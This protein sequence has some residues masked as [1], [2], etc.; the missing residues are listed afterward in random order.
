MTAVLN[1]NEQATI[2]VIEPP[3]PVAVEPRVEALQPLRA[4]KCGICT[5]TDGCTNCSYES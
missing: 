1:L 5:K 4:M 2:E 3:Q